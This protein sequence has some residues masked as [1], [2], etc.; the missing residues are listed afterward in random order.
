MKQR[1]KELIKILKEVRSEDD[2]I[3]SDEVIFSEAL[4]CYRGEQISKKSFNDESNKDA[5]ATK[6]QLDFIYKNN[7]NVDT[8][9][10]TKKE[11]QVLIK[12]YLEKHGKN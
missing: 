3:V 8:E 9:T 12:D 10:L 2:L 1:I 5:M 7:L 11:A 6:K 4:T